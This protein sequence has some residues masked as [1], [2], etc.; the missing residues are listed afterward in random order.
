MVD[1]EL[2]LVLELL[3]NEGMNLSINWELDNLALWIL[4]IIL[5]LTLYIFLKIHILLWQ[6]MDR[7]LLTPCTL[8]NFLIW[9]KLTLG[10]LFC[11]LFS[12]CI[13]CYAWNCNYFVMA[14]KFVTRPMSYSS[15]GTSFFHNNGWVGWGRVF[16]THWVH[17]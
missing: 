12:A 9:C 16:K 1:W 13:S 8:D 2:M 6:I 17:V 4:S 7:E 14:S 5:F 15:I 10:I 11:L 3:Q